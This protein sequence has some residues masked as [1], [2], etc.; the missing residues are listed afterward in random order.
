M[1][2]IPS[3]VVALADADP[4]DKLRFGGK[5]A[6]LA[7]MAGL[8]LP[9]PPAF[10]GTTDLCREFLAGPALPDGSWQQIEEALAGLAARTGRRFG[11]PQAPLLVSVR[12]GAPV[13][14]PG[15]MDTILN[16]GLTAETLPGLVALTGDEAFAWD[17]YCRLLKMFGDTVRDLPAPLLAAAGREAEA[18][19]G[20][21]A[22]RAE[23]LRAVAAALAAAIEAESGAPIPDSPSGQLREAV[24]AVLSSWET[25]RA[26]RY[27]RHAGIDDDL[28]TA[29]IVQAMVF[30]NLDE[31][32]GS[33]VAFTRDPTSGEPVIYGD[34][35]AGAQG[36]DVVSGEF[37]V[38]SLAEFR[39]ASPEAYEELERAAAVLERAYADMCDIEFTVE[40]GRLWILQARA[41]QRTGVAEVRIAADLLEE[42]AIDAET[43]LDRISPAGLIRVAAPVF[44]PAAPRQVLGSGI[45]ASP[46]AA[47]GGLATSAR[48]AEQ[49]AAAGERV[50][51]ARP[52]TSPDDIA[53]FIAADGVLTAR[54]GRASHA[55]VV[56]RGLNLP[57]VCG[58]VGLEVSEEGI[59][60]GGVEVRE[61]EPIS[62]DGASGEILA[63]SVPLVAP[64]LDSR[65]VALL[66]EL[67]RGPGPPLLAREEAEWADARLDEADLTICVSA[68]EVEQAAAA[69]ATR[70]LVDLASG[71]DPRATLA[72]AAELD[73]ERTEVLVRVGTNWP[74]AVRR[75]PPGPWAGILADPASQLAARLLATSSNP[76]PKEKTVDGA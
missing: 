31:R 30:G 6:S 22:P 9:V 62:L 7:T 69:G 34:F 41:G 40:R 59:R 51:L 52:A 57:A 27:R 45:P 38:G 32:S 13:S 72:R 42:G 76:T 11:D 54:G 48:R 56:A 60:I 35:L 65:V 36:E 53:G 15:M 33:G 17:S 43:A 61:G 20:A 14:M 1:H 37:E 23:R 71:S 10:I 24:G 19:V 4:D 63:G 73:R 39:A 74:P 18:A 68:A 55:A 67:E 25:P 28:G 21:T 75:L 66:G 47:V 44:D 50:I 3:L 29:V 58:V 16:V 49:L 26:R 2:T 46:G 12:S 5:G 70:I 8:G 64:G